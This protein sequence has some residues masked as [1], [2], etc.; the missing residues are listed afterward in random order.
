RT[1]TLTGTGFAAN[2]GNIAITLDGTNVAT[3]SSDANG[4]LSCSFTAPTTPG[5]YTVTASDGTN[6]AQVTYTVSSVSATTLVVSGFTSPT[7]SAAH[8]DQLRLTT[9]D[10]P[11]PYPWESRPTSPTA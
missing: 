2:N 6:S 8:P 9:A 10:G 3:C 5:T 4:G 11:S 1:V 7:V